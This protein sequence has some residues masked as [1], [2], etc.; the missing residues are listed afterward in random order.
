MQPKLIAD[1]LI[2]LF[3]ISRSGNLAI[4]FSLSQIGGGP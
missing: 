1:A 4:S 3:P 2:P